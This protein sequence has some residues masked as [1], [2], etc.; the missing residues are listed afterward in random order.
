MNQT[1]VGETAES[2]QLSRTDSDSLLAIVSKDL[3]KSLQA[4]FDMAGE[5]IGKEA[6]LVRVNRDFDLQQLEP[7]AGVVLHAVVAE[8]S[9]HVGDDVVHA[10]GR[11]DL[12]AS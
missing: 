9:Y 3:E 12:A 8:R 6:P 11:R 7:A 10:Q 5:Y 4:A 1:Y 2:K